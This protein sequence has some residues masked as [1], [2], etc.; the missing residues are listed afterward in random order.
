P[1]GDVVEGEC[2]DVSDVLF[3]DVRTREAIERSIRGEV[4]RLDCFAVENVS[5]C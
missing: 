2:S 1:R 5:G 3:G 4:C